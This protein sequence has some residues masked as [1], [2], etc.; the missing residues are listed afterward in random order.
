[1]GI[2]RRVLNV[3]TVTAGLAIVVSATAEICGAQSVIEYTSRPSAVF[4]MG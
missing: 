3:M 2:A 1:M 4:P